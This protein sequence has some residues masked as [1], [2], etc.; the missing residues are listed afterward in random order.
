MTLG[1]FLVVM[2]L[3]VNLL[4]TLPYI[5]DT[6]RGSTK[7]NRVTWFLWALAPLIS[8][9]IAVNAGAD[10]WIT[11]PVF[12]SGFLPLIVFIVSFLNNEAYWELRWFDWLCGAFS[13]IAFLTWLIAS[14]AATAIIFAI[15]SDFFAGIPTLQKLWHFPETET[16]IT[17]VFTFL[18]FILAAFAIPIWNV[19]N[20]AFQIYLLVM[21]FALMFAAYRK[22]VLT[23]LVRA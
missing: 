23:F 8:S 17:F 6:F 14:A 20:A 9:V 16:R 22:E 5:L 10:I 15:I 3:V 13:L 11:A 1:H 2:S 4:A 21:N 7:P 12:L 19:E 18:S